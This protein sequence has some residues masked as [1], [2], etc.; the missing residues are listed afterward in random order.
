MSKWKEDLANHITESV[1]G[2]GDEP[3]SPCQRIQFMG[4]KYPNNEK[5]QGG[6]SKQGFYEHI[7]K[8]LNG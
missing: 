2:L 3:N 5:T 4:G 1:F 7:L 6:F 8:L